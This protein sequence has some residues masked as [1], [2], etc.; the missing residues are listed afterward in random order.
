MKLSMKSM[1]NSSPMKILCK[2]H[3]IMKMLII[4]GALFTVVYL[5]RSNRLERFEDKVKKDIEEK[6][7]T[8][9]KEVSEIK[10]AM[11]KPA[12]VAFTAEWCGHCKKLKPEWKKLVEDNDKKCLLVNADNEKEKELH[13]KHKI[14]GFPT[15]RFYP[16]GLN[17]TSNYIEHSGE[18]SAKGLKA[19]LKKHC[20]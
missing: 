2:K 5:Y 15:I 18:R 9:D 7:E 1:L 4:L 11:D 16:K 20:Q 10:D 13:K 12:L 19:F 3:N 6:K 8:A 14:E 17:D